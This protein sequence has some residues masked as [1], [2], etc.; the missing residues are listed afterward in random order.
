MFKDSRM[1]FGFCLLL[2]LGTLAAIIALGKVEEKTSYGLQYVLGGLTT[3][4]GGFAQWAFSVKQKLQTE[5]EKSEKS[6][7]RDVKS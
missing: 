1:M 7:E 3:L 4:A 6:E 5:V 2:I